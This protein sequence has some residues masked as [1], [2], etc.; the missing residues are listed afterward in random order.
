MQPAEI[1]TLIREGL[2]DATV[3]VQDTTG[4]GDHFEALVVSRSFSGKGLVE[5]H[6]LVYASLKGAM[7]DRIHAL[8]LKTLTPEEWAPR[9]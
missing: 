3:Q 6:Q 7:A 9:R 2:P 8:A 5:R 4:G 1:E